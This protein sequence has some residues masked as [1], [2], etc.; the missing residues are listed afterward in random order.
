MKNVKPY[1]DRK[2]EYEKRHVERTLNYA[3]KITGLDLQISK[4]KINNAVKCVQD[5]WDKLVGKCKD[6][7][8]SIHKTIT[9][10]DLLNAFTMHYSKPAK[11]LFGKCANFCETP[12]DFVI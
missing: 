6:G 7:N 10:S 3:S 4:A 12:F 8:I 1:N 5:K 2:I 9:E 11:E